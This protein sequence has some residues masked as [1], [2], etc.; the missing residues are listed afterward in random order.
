MAYRLFD[1]ELAKSS[2]VT[3]RR[4]K[5]RRCE[6]RRSQLG[7]APFTSRSCARLVTETTV[8]SMRLCERCCATGRG[9]N[10]DVDAHGI[11]SWPT[12]LT[13]R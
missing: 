8:E 7:M 9:G 13:P 10:L 11:R 3:G 5:P 1:A 12:W 2:L 6:Q 4:E